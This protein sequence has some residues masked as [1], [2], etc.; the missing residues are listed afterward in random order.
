MIRNVV[1]IDG[2]WND[3]A[4]QTNVSKISHQAEVLTKIIP[5]Q[6]DDGVVQ[7]VYYHDGVGVAGGPVERFLGGAIGIGLKQIV[8]DA[9]DWVVDN[10]QPDQELY[11][12][13]FSRG[14]Y[15]ARAL[16]GLIGA[17][18]IQREKDPKRFE[19]SWKNYRMR[20]REGEERSSAG[21]RIRTQSYRRIVDAGEMHHHNRI[22]C[23]GVWD[24]VG[25]YGVP[26]GFGF[27]SLARF[28]A[29]WQLG[30]HDTSFGKHINHGLHAVGVDERRRPFTP[31]FWSAPNG[32][33]P[34]RNVEQTWFSGVHC[35]IGGGYPQDSRLSDLTLLWLI[36]RV[37]KLTRLAFDTAQIR[38]RLNPHVDGEVF[39]SSKGWPISSVFPYQRP[40]FASGAL[41]KGIFS[42]SPDETERHINERVHWS[43][44]AKLGRKGVVYGRQTAYDPPNLPDEFKQAANWTAP[45]VAPRIAALTPEEE[46]LL[47]EEL[48]ELARSVAGAPALQDA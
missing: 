45:H 13:G 14:A 25:S 9:Y 5:P 28:W 37:R 8:N 12:F 4:S 3:E 34:P 17:S 1:L 44:L 11:I 24:T 38:A 6:G 42:N 48:V 10:Y 2:T 39:D 26:A 18:G 16:A 23:V 32:E 35:N 36:A 43:V 15:A 41:A 30:F 40:M 46:A 31:T 19:V 7:Q 33:P 21:G 27:E 29:L 47:P 20:G 22:E